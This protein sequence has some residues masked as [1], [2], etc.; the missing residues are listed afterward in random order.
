MRE[1]LLTLYE[2][3]EHGFAAPLPGFV[4]AELEAYVD[5]GVLARGFSVLACPDCQERKVTAFSCKGLAFCPACLGRRMAATAAN[6]VEHVI[7][8]AAPLRQW[9][10]TLPFELRARL[11]YDG[12]LLGA[13]CRTFVDCVLAWYRRKMGARGS[14]D[15][16]SGAVTAVQRVSSDFRLNPHFHSLALDG[17]YVDD[18]GGVLTFQALPCLTNDDVAEVLQIARTRIIALLRRKGVL[19][20][21]DESGASLSFVTADEALAES[22]PALAELAAASVTGRVPA[23]PALRKREP[24]KLR[25]PGEPALT[26]ALCATEQGFSLHAATTASADDAAGREALCKYILRPPLSQD[27]IQ[28][29]AGDLVRL[30]LKRPFSDG[31]FALDLDPLS[32]LARLAASVHPPRFNT[33]RYAGVL[34]AASTWRSRV[35]PPPPPAAEND[36]DH[37]CLLGSTKKEKPP[38]HRSGYRPWKELLKR[39]FKIDVERCDRCGGRMK[40]RAL[41]ITSA[42]IDRYLTW[43]GEP[44]APPTLGPAR[45]PPFFK[46]VIIRRKLGEPV[47]AEL[48]DAH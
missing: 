6:L 2:A 26:K 34:G 29:V 1:N 38:T 48:F 22:E 43:L 40:L 3:A 4:R 42:G 17:V 31:T 23:G 18:E 9:V 16:K 21:D 39:S 47:Q 20:D 7:P 5:C 13:V 45:G 41:V 35:V 24:I 30:V 14:K 15:G 32:L 46:S 10:L 25:A 12:K 33:V 44:T 36:H 27:R 37:D 11:A 28:L 19:A 8:A